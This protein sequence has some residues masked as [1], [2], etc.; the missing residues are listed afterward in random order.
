MLVVFVVVGL[1]YLVWAP[2]ARTPTSIPDGMQEV[3]STPSTST[4]VKPGSS[5]FTYQN[6]SA[7]IIIVDLPFPDA[8]TGKEFSVRGKAR[9]PWFFEASF[10]VFLLDKNNNQ[11]AEAIATVEPP[12]T[13]WMT[14][15]FVP[16]KADIITPK[17]YIGPATLV[18]MKDNPS[19]DPAH[20]ASVSFLITVEY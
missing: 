11:I 14:N 15:D 5:G 6:A 2:E 18:L 8:V 3:S 12:T 19:G 4:G 1:V 16:F 13:N 17:S 9:G 10:P 20:D 7:D